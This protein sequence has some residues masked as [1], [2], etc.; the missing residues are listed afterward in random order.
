MDGRTRKVAKAVEDA[1]ETGERHRHTQKEGYEGT[2]KGEKERQR[3]RKN[4]GNADHKCSC[5]L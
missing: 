4:T 2:R 1:G 3:G 5:P